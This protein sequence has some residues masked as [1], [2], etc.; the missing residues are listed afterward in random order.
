MASSGFCDTPLMRE[1]LDIVG[2]TTTQ[3][4]ACLSNKGKNQSRGMGSQ[5]LDAMVDQLP[6]RCAVCVEF[7]PTRSTLMGSALFEA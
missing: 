5:V 7:S 2:P 6:C 1:M 3:S 4:K